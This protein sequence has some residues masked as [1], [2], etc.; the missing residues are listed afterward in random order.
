LFWPKKFKNLLPQ[1]ITG[2]GAGEVETEGRRRGGRG[3]RSGIKGKKE[4][5]GRRRRRRV[6]KTR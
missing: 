5:R 4:R 6:S 1:G 2:E 3:R